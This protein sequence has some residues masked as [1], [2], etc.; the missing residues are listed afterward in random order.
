MTT[1]ATVTRVLDQ[2]TRMSYFWIDDIHVTGAVREAVEEDVVLYNWVNSF[3]TS[4]IQY[5]KEILRGSF[6]TPE[7]MVAGDIRAEEVRLV[8]GKVVR[9]E[10]CYSLTEQGECRPCLHKSLDNKLIGLDNI[11]TEN[12]RSSFQFF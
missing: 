3:L 8:W 4:H 11:Q 9:C 1:P 10:D 5:S 6:Y 12:D 7:L 2:S